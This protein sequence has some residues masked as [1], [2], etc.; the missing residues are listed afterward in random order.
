MFKSQLVLATCLAVA[1]PTLAGTA[2]YTID[3]DH[4]YPSLEMSHM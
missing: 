4:T 3:S 1:L 2:N